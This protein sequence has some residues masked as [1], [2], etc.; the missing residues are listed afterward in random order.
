VITLY[1]YELSGNCYKVRLALNIL[2]VPFTARPMD[3][4]PGR[5]H[6][7]DWFL[8]LNPQGQLPVIDDEGLLLREAQ[9]ILVYLASRYDASGYWYPRQDAAALGRI[10]QWLGFADSLTATA[11]AARLHDTM[12]LEADI[13]KC[14]ASAHALLRILDEH[15]WFAEQAGEQWLCT[16]EQ[17]SIADLACFP[18]VMLSEEGGISRLPYPAIRRWAERVKRVPGFIPMSGIFR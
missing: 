7:S 10:T 9:A 8:R 6:K 5:E 1:D 4:H 2:R 14:R 11:G 16:A 3:F 18:Y 12:F 17:P 13:G 15:L